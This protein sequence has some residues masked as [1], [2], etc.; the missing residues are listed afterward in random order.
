[1]K[2]NSKN[3]SD[4]LKKYSIGVFDMLPTSVRAQ[5]IEFAWAERKRVLPKVVNL[6]S[7]LRVTRA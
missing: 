2:S 1:M 5:M 7:W 3:G 4:A 6:G